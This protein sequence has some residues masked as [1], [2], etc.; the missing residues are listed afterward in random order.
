MTLGEALEE[1]V[2]CQ[3]RFLPVVVDARSCSEL[4]EW[5]P[6]RRHW[7]SWEARQGLKG[8]A[9]EGPGLW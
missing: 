1:E 5:E 4:R 9:S 8:P 6:R 2:G 7:W 3:G